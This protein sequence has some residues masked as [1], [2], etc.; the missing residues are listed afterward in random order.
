M[1]VVA[2]LSTAGATNAT[3]YA[4][5]NLTGMLADEGFFPQWFGSRSRLGR[6]GGLVITTALVLVVANLVDLS[7]IA[8]V[9]SAVSLTVFLLIGLAGWKRRTDTASNAALVIGAIGVI[10][11]VLAFFAVDTL[12][13]DPATFVATLA[14]CVLAV[15]LD[16]LWKRRQLRDRAVA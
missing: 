11:V 6:N 7:A 16:A 2:L 3:L 1:A 15:V 10:A 4:S 12:R 9:G 8:S 14:I 13:N 5:G